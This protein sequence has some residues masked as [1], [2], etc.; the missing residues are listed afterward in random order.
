MKMFSDEKNIRNQKSS[1]Q[2]RQKKKKKKKKKKEKRMVGKSFHLLIEHINLSTLL[3]LGLATN[4]KW[5]SML[6]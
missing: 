2:Q 3:C 4:W 1:L 6:D 5:Y